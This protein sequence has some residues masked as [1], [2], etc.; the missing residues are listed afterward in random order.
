MR[1]GLLL[2]LAAFV[3]DV[4][5]EPSP[6]EPHAATITAA[7]STATPAPA[8]ARRR[9]CREVFTCLLLLGSGTDPGAN[10]HIRHYPCQVPTEAAWPGVVR[11]AAWARSRR[12]EWARS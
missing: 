6:L 10:L 8:L 2:A 4:D 9:A 12:A 3:V 1:T 7:I 11:R 5:D